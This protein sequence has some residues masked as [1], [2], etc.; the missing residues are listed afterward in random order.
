MAVCMGASPQSRWVRS[1]HWHNMKK[2]SSKQAHI[3]AELAKI[4]S[5][6][7][8]R[9]AICGRYGNDLSHILPRSLYMEYQ[10]D[11]RNLQILCRECHVRFDNDRDFRRKQ[12]KIVE[13]AKQIDECAAN[14]YF[15]L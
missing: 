11:P 6:L 12:T 3:N 2:I 15:G 4:K 7:T 14:R 9:C 5:S 13:Q 8:K 1:H 10:I